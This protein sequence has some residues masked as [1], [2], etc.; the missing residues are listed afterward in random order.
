M[1]LK[2]ILNLF[3]RNFINIYFEVLLVIKFKMLTE[4][5]SKQFNPMKHMHL[6]NVRKIC[7]NKNSDGKLVLLVA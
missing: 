5:L 2:A 6:K 4:M 1:V 3:F 7:T